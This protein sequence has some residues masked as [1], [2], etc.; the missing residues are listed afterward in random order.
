MGNNAHSNMATTVKK[1]SKPV[2]RGLPYWRRLFKK[3]LPGYD[4]FADSD[5]FR[6][7]CDAANLSVD[8]FPECLIHVK[9]KLAGEPLHLEDWEVAFIGCLFGWKEANTKLRRYREAFLFIPRKNGKSTLAAGVAIYTTYCD[10]EPGAEVYCAAAGKEQAELVFGPAKT[11]VLNEPY[12]KDRTR[13]YAASLEVS[14]TNNKTVS[15]MKVLT[16]APK[17]KHGYNVHAVIIDELHAHESPEL[18]EVLM[19]GTGARTQP[20]VVH[21]TTS[22]FD[23]EGSICNRKHEEASKIRDGLVSD[24]R[25]LPCV[26]EATKDDDWTKPATWRKANPN[27]GVSVSEGYLA[28]ECAR[29]QSSPAYENTFKRLHLNIRTEQA[30]RWIQM[31]SWDACGEAL[32]KIDLHGRKCYAGLDMASTRDVTALSLIF[33]SEDSDPTNATYDVHNWYWVPENNERVLG[34][35]EAAI[36]KPWIGQGHIITTPGN[37]TDYDIVRRDIVELA[38]LFGIVE[39]AIDRWNSTQLQTQLMGEGVE[40]IKFGQGFASMSAPT[41]ALDALIV[42][43]RIRHMADPVTRWMVSNASV[44]IDEAGNIKPN[45]E[46]STGKIDGVVA[47]IMALGRAMVKED[48]TSI[49]ENPDEEMFI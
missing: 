26:Y 47:M 9:G 48:T 6:F 40:V 4:P 3:H 7:D 27:L 35:G 8:F 16:K 17:T 13:D 37:V 28:R 10:G 43:G 34:Y 38:A 31:A 32:S 15:H 11:M 25:F 23:R 5:G 1:P 24:P 22:D 49:W 21:I 30:E 41:K 19:T 45:K 46:K 2:K 20:I 44:K 18:V 39:L 14:D 36:Y 33:P 42:S 29:A 12:L